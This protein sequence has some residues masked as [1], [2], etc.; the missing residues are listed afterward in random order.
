M[1]SLSF[2]K[3]KVSQL[4]PSQARRKQQ[5]KLNKKEYSQK[6]EGRHRSMTGNH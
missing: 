3:K 2:P 5:N 1:L 6:E 4:L